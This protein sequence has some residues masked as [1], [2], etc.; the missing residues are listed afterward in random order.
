MLLEYLILAEDE[1]NLIWALFVMKSFIQQMNLVKK[2]DKRLTNFKGTEWVD[3]LL[4]VVYISTRPP[5]SV[6]L[7]A[8]SIRKYLSIFEVFLKNI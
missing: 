3:V 5:H 6:D 2:K 7:Y 8:R 4:R 1:G